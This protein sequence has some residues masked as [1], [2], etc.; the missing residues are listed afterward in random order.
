M[1]NRAGRFAHA[2]R[3]EKR[4]DALLVELG[5]REVDE[6]KYLLHFLDRDTDGNEH[7]GGDPMGVEDIAEAAAE[8]IGAE[9]LLAYVGAL[10]H[11]IGKMNKPEYFVENQ[12]AGINKHDKLSPAMS[13][14]IV[15]GHVKDGMELARE[16]SVPANI[17]H[18]IEAH[19]GT[20]LVEFFYH[21]ARQR[22][23]ESVIRSR[24]RRD[25]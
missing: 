22:A 20:T 13:L 24:P 17:Q 7:N 23:L 5:S 16:F 2:N 11:D 6:A 12:S 10:Y 18:F 4:A 8:S 25:R 14:L 1:A 21:R 9:G 15:V 19:H 3:M